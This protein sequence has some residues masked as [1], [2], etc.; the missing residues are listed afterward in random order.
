MSRISTLAVIFVI[1]SAFNAFPKTGLAEKIFNLSHFD[2]YI[3]FGVN[4]DHSIAGLGDNGWD[5]PKAG[6]YSTCWHKLP[7]GGSIEIPSGY[8]Q[9]ARVL[10]FGNG[11][12]HVVPPEQSGEGQFLPLPKDSTK[13]GK[14]YVSRKHFSARTQKQDIF[15]RGYSSEYF[16][17]L[18]SY[19]PSGKNFYCVL[20][21]KTTRGKVESMLGYKKVA[22]AGIVNKSQ[23][24]VK[25]EV[26]TTQNGSW[27]ELT[28]QPNQTRTFWTNVKN[29]AF[30]IKFDEGIGVAGT[31]E[32][33]YKLKP[34]EINLKPND[35]PQFEQVS[36][37]KFSA[38]GN[39]MKL[40]QN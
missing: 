8:N 18:N 37:Y 15:K 22:A 32:R 17:P 28:L 31:Q 14:C 10:V 9:F 30:E 38:S 23:L 26:R 2:V 16:Y 20:A 7:A 34:Y 13:G 24:P 1:F 6:L 36:Q 25:F 5:D 40:F 39:R 33:A 21:S 3:A 35:N 11:T 29:Y 19:K 27:T 4:K 12:S